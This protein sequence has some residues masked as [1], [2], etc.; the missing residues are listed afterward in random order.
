M[1]KKEIYEK[2]AVAKRPIDFF[3]EFEKL[4]ELRDF[5]KKT[6]KSL[7]EDITSEEERYYSNEAVLLLQRL[8]VR[9]VNEYDNGTY[10][11]VSEEETKPELKKI[12]EERDA[13][14]SFALLVDGKRYDFVPAKIY[15]DFYDVFVTTQVDE[16]YGSKLF[17]KIPWYEDKNSLL[18]REFEFLSHFNHLQLPQPVRMVEIEDKL[19]TMYAR[20]EGEQLSLFKRSISVEHSLWMLERLLG[21]VGF[22][23]YHQ[24]VHGDLTPRNITI[25]TDTHNVMLIGNEYVI[26]DAT[27]RETAKYVRFNGPYTAPEDSKKGAIVNPRS[28]I[29][30]IGKII[31]KILQGDVVAGTIPD[32][33]ERGIDKRVYEMIMSM[34]EKDPENRPGDAWALLAYLRKLRDDIYGEDR[35]KIFY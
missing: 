3:G 2:L 24:I 18:K 17:I 23:Q 15:A 30:S 34:V 20:I 22:L 6:M 14:A 1:T 9:A 5:Q 33:E 21:V 28:D 12:Y 13:K 31:I 8:F 25:D 10:F 35:F 4:G 7:Q 11:I 29:Y 32:W 19:A 26:Q 27:N 16:K